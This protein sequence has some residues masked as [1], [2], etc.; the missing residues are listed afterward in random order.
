MVLA[1]SYELDRLDVK[2]VSPGGLVL[3]DGLKPRLGLGRRSKGLDE[4]GESRLRRPLKRPRCH[5]TTGNP[6][7]FGPLDGLVSIRRRGRSHRSS[8]TPIALRQ[9]T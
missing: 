7:V 9:R 2:H 1:A 5:D 6:D 3:E 4:P 8:P